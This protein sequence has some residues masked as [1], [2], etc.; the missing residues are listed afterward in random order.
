M[1][2]AYSGMVNRKHRPAAIDVEAAVESFGVGKWSK[3][4][5]RQEEGSGLAVGKE[6]KR[7]YKATLLGLESTMLGGKVVRHIWGE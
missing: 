6:H 1:I 3:S 4:D 2:F 5:K 7:G